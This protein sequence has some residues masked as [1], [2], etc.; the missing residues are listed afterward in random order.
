[1]DIK[2]CPKCSSE[3][4]SIEGNGFCASITC[5]DCEYTRGG[6]SGREMLIHIWNNDKIRNNYLI[7]RKKVNK[8]DLQS[9][10]LFKSN[11]AILLTMETLEY[12]NKNYLSGDDKSRSISKVKLINQMIDELNENVKYDKGLNSQ[13]ERG[14]IMLKYK[15]KSYCPYCETEGEKEYSLPL[16]NDDIECVSCGGFTEQKIISIKE[17]NYCDCSKCTGLPSIEDYYKD[18]E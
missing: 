15:I 7:E 14:N 2:P 12:E 6:F 3:E 17:V 16:N 5:E 11:L 8:M 10:T 13:G 18:E 4:V 1:M 9:K